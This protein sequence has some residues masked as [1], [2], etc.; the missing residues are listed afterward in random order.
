MNPLAASGTA[1]EE[2]DQGGEPRDR[3]DVEGEDPDGREPVPGARRGREPEEDGDDDD[4]GGGD[5]VAGEGATTCPASTAE[6][7]IGIVR[8]RS[9]I[10]RDMSVATATAVWAAPNPARSRI[11]PGYHIVH[12]LALDAEGR[13]RRRTRTWP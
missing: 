2:T 7:V 3:Q 5:G 13:H 9:T 4:A 1:G 8:S 11:A 6:E 10:P 12:V